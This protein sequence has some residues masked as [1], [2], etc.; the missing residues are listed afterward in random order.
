MKKSK[1]LLHK[2]KNILTRKGKTNNSEKILATIF[3]ILHNRGY[4][5]LNVFTLA[6]NNVKPLVELKKKKVRGTL[7]IIPRPISL[8]VQLSKAIKLIISAGKNSNKPISIALADEIISSFN[9]FGQTFRESQLLHK[10]AIQ[11]K[12]FA[13]YRWF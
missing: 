10:Q 3:R 7:Q 1:F 13:S 8:K 2:F 6:V 9:R 4:N 12:S 11:N 5:A